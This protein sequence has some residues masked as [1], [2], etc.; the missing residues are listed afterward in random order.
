MSTYPPSNVLKQ[1]IIEAFQGSPINSQ[2]EAYIQN[3]SDVFGGAEI[4]CNRR[5]AQV[6]C[7]E[8][9]R[10]AEISNEDASKVISVL[11][12]YIESGS[13]ARE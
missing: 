8:M 7:F 10:Q 13:C 11:C 2:L 4:K 1:N 3:V 5:H 9:K 12:S 6:K